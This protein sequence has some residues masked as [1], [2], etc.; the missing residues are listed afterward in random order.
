MDEIEAAA[1]EDEAFKAL[2]GHTRKHSV[3]VVSDIRV[4][5]I[6]REEIG[7]AKPQMRNSWGN[8]WLDNK[9]IRIIPGDK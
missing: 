1:R 7:K 9:D 4:R 5:E 2:A 8:V 3:F 6:V